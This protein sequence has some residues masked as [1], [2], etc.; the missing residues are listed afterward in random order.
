[1]MKGQWQAAEN[2]ILYFWSILP[3]LLA[4]GRAWSER[5]TTIINTACQTLVSEKSQFSFSKGE[6]QIS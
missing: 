4:F 6:V 3:T 1:M 5:L 2:G